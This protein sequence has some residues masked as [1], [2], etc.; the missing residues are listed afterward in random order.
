M[1]YTVIYEKSRNG[2]GAYLPDLPGCVATG[3]TLPLVKRRIREA[4]ALHIQGM[5]EDGDNIPRPTTRVEQV[6]VEAA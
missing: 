5:R 4:V 2:W 1:Q 3:R 6:V